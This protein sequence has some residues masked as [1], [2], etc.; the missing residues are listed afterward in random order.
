LHVRPVVGI[1]ARLDHVKGIDV[2]LR[3]T[4]DVPGIDLALV[5][6]GPERTALEQQASA[7]GIASRVTFVDWTESPRDALAGFDIFVLPSRHEGLPLSI[8]EA[9]LAG[10]PVVATNV[11]SVAE[12]VLDGTTGYVVPPEDTVALSRALQDLAED[13]AR[14][15]RMGAAGRARALEHFTASRMAAMYENL[16]DTVLFD[17]RRCAGPPCLRGRTNRFPRPFTIHRK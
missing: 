16:Y 1:L 15:E 13:P 10:L 6:R 7:L 3:S 11:G 8:V 12:A 9:M 14:R 5:G 17:P 2:L 4:V